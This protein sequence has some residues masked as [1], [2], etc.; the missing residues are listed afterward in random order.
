MIALA[1]AGL[2]AT[3]G[4]CGTALTAEQAALLQRMG[5]TVVLLFDGDSAGYRAALRAL[6]VVVGVV[7]EVRVAFPPRGMDPDLWV[8]QVGGEAVRTALGE[9]RPP[10]AFLEEQVSLG[11]L[12]KREAVDRAAELLARVTDPLHRE[13]WL[14][15]AASRFG[16]RVEAFL[17]KLG[18]GRPAVPAQPAPGAAQPSA[19]R[20]PWGR[21][22]A[23]CL[24]S[25]LAEPE[26][27]GALA[28]ALEAA[29]SRSPAPG[30]LRWI[31]EL[32]SS[33][34][35]E[36][37]PAR[38]LALARK[39]CESGPALNALAL[40][41]TSPPVSSSDLLH[42]LESRRTKKRMEAIGREIRRAEESGDQ[43]SLA[44]LLAEKQGLARA[45]AL[46]KPESDAWPDDAQRGEEP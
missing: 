41:E 31:A 46:F 12:P 29:G 25:A 44:R 43:E 13:L 39:E 2:E 34:D 23:Q 1:Q 40:R 8:R 15:E 30:L 4:S 17:E 9:A 27:A 5:R 38:I 3:V 6:P 16:L 42:H 18:S 19:S 36:L 37:T 11:A 22:E 32:V 20:E 14:Q 21:F 35:L 10:L 28:G 45:Q 33:A 7:D 24:L 26:A